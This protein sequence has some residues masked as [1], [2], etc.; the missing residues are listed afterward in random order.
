MLCCSMASGEMSGARPYILFLGALIT[1]AYTRYGQA[2]CCVCMCVCVQ[3]GRYPQILMLLAASLLLL[4]AEGIVKMVI[5]S[6]TVMGIFYL[7]QTA[8]QHCGKKT[9]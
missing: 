9:A 4:N 6:I 8:C 2:E 7:E 5:V 3:N 1:T